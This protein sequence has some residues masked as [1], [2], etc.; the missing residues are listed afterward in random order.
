M[1]RV[2]VQP[3]GT[4]RPSIEP[5]LQ[6][7]IPAEGSASLGP[8][9]VIKK[10]VPGEWIV[11]TDPVL[12]RQVWL[13]RKG[14]SGLSLA[15]QTAARPGR[16]RWLQEVRVGGVAWDAFEATRGTPFSRLVEAGQRLPWGTLRHWL[17][18]LA[19]EMWA[20][21][22]DQTLPA[23]LSLGHV[24]ITAEGRAILLDEPWPDATLHGE[25]IPVG[26]IAGQQRFLNAV[27]A[28]VEIHQ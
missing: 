1:T 11:A 22:V 12:R 10:I 5:A 16:F 17:H 8:Y 15:R 23:E 4:V 14:S 21:T 28:F 18:D 7:Q 27:A 26:D 9:P 24:W 19:S 25:R 6:L 20:A 13:L 3:K 2:V